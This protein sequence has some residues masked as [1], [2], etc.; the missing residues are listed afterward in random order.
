MSFTR[1]K[2]YE[3]SN[4]GY[5][6]ENGVWIT[7]GS[8]VPSHAA[9]DG[10]RFF[11]S[12]GTQW[13]YMTN[14]IAIGES[15]IISGGSVTLNGVAAPQLTSA[16]TSF[17]VLA[18]FIYRGSNLV[19]IPNSIRILAWTSATSG[20]IKFFDKTNGN[21]IVEKNITNSVEAV[22]DMGTLSNIPTTEAVIEIQAKKTGGGAVFIAAAVLGL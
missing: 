7:S 15:D 9:V 5:L 21:T 6:M 3:V 12:N 16:Q 22:I 13:R 11:Q 10:D 18:K 2:A 17:K 1:S 4:D 20:D 14:W 8:G 19:G